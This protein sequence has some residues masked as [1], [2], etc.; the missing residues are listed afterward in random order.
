MIEEGE[1]LATKSEDGSKF[2]ESMSRKGKIRVFLQR[3]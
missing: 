1:L 3:W 2:N